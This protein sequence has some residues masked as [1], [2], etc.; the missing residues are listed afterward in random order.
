METRRVVGRRAVASVGPALGGGLLAE[1]LSLV[2]CDGAT[3]RTGTLERRS[4]LPP[5]VVESGTVHSRRAIPGG[6]RE[7]C[8]PGVKPS[9]PS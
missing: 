7:N 6:P 3:E 9:T 8:G 2:F 1:R 5:R 4:A